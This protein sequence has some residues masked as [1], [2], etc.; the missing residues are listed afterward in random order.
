MNFNNGI[1]E[2]IFYSRFIASWYNSGGKRIKSHVDSERR[3]NYFV[4]WL[5]TLTV[6]GKQIPDNVIY[7]IVEIASNGKAELEWNV[8]K[9]FKENGLE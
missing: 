3:P 5:R 6:N 1:F 4:R 9:F 8:T 7:D 2:G